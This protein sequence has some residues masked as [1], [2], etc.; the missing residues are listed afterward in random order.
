MTEQQAIRRIS[1][2]GQNVVTETIKL[3]NASSSLD[4]AITD[5]QGARMRMYETVTGRR[6][7]QSNHEIRQILEEALLEDDV[8]ARN[9][10]QHEELDKIG[11]NGSLVAAG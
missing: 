10:A 5:R 9:R 6:E 1:R 11:D 3:V 2:I 8:Q 7:I 4:M